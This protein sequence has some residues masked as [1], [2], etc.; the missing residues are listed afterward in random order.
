[1]KLD[2]ATLDRFAILE[3]KYDPGLEMALSCGIG[4]PGEPWK[5]GAP[6]NIETQE[7]YVKWVQSVRAHCGNSV[8]IS[9]RCS[10]NGCR[11][12]RC[13]IRLQEVAD[14]LVFKLV[15]DDSR[16]RIVQ[17]CGLPKEVA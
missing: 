13:G 11:A 15:A 9:P 7:A 10:I 2:A 8:L 1:V 12:L 6:A 17:T 3:I 5:A 14:A 16:Q 4:Q